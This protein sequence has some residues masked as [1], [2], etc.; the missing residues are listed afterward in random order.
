MNDKMKEALQRQ[1]Q[2]EQKEGNNG[3][4]DE[5]KVEIPGA[6]DGGKKSRYRD[7]IKDTMK[8]ERLDGYESE[9][10]RYYKSLVK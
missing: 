7:E 3:E 1:R 9:I 4:L 2:K 6:S 10:E 5:E 8:E